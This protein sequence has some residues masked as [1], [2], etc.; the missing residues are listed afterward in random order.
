MNTRTRRLAVI[1][2]AAALLVGCSAIDPGE[3][4]A[5]Q[6]KLSTAE[7]LPSTVSLGDPFLPTDIPRDQIPYT[8]PD[9]SLGS[10][11]EPGNIDLLVSNSWG[12]AIVDVQNER[13]T[14]TSGGHE[15]WEMKVISPI[16]GGADTGEVLRIVMGTDDEHGSPV[17]RGK[18]YRKDERIAV[19]Y[20]HY[21]I[22]EARYPEELADVEWALPNSGVF[23]FTGETVRASTAAESFEIINQ[24]T[25]VEVSNVDDLAIRVA[26]VLASQGLDPNS[27]L[28]QDER[29]DTGVYVL[30]EDYPYEEG[31]PEYDEAGQIVSPGGRVIATAD[32]VQAWI[33]SFRE[34]DR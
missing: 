22:A 14:V 5:R 11:G 15:I 31:K 18:R 28:E 17:L 7:R 16:F 2:P 33:E 8:E 19:F 9:G 21:Q 13:P 1:V 3:S 29:P 12:A 23:R 6:S 30:P 26:E 10:F 4:S 27:Y 24:G 32:E 25:I 34:P 20:R